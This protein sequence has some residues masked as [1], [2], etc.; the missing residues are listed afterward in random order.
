MSGVRLNIKDIE[1][2]IQGTVHGAIADAAVAAL[3][4]EP[5]TVAE[6]EAALARYMELPEDV[7]PF[8]TFLVVMNGPSHFSDRS[9]GAHGLSLPGPIIDTETI[10][11]EPWDAGLLIIDLAARI[12]A[13]ESTYSLPQTQG[14]IQYHD[15][16]KATDV[17]V[18]YRV[19]DDWLF[20]YSL[21]EY[22]AVR[23]KRCLERAANPPLDARAV[24]YGAA[25]SE[26]ILLECLAAREAKAKES[27]LA[28]AA[29]E[30]EMVEPLAQELG[31]EGAND[32][33]A[34]QEETEKAIA[35]IHAHWLTTPR[36]ELRGQAPRDLLLA[37]REF[38]DFDLH[39]RELQWSFRGEGP[40]CLASDSH[41]F[42]FAGFGTHECVIYYDLLR[43]LLG[44]CW[45][46]LSEA[47]DI[48]VEIEIALLEVSKRSWLEL[49][50]PEYGG[51]IPAVIA[52][53]ERKRLPLALSAR[54]MVVDEDCPTC[55]MMAD[56][57]SL[58]FGPGFWHLD[59]CNIDDDFVF[60]FS[61]TRE[62]WEAERRRME[63]FNEKFNREWEL[64]Q[65]QQ[66]DAEQLLNANQLPDP[67]QLLDLELPDA[68]DQSSDL[69]Q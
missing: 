24:L 48:D 21:S 50:Q 22:K 4:A 25:L 46:R 32:D 35:T 59:G 52:E 63:E 58:D 12:V 14:E 19:P 39:T 6:L 57:M 40:P 45:L 9:P 1:R 61:R 44:E 8:A 55:Q 17:A 69:I 5:E 2:T 18:L 60:S 56:E 30:L 54:D 49:P 15:G 16:I 33:E 36:E 26:F 34:L 11:P 47:Q 20:V 31:L 65:W 64:N 13:A 28:A 38:I 42:R 29:N 66:L 37:K 43:H 53:N 10:N 27:N 41:G 3:S 51:K 68:D 62:E 7:S 23:A 67:E